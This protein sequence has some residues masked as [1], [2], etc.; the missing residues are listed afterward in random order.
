MTTGQIRGLQCFIDLRNTGRSG[1]TYKP[2][3]KKGHILVPYAWFL[4]VTPIMTDADI[5]TALEAAII[6]GLHND[7]PL[8]RWQFIGKYEGFEDKSEAPTMQK[9][10]YGNSVKVNDGTYVHE[11]M[12]GNGQDYHNV[13]RTYDGKQDQFKVLA[14]DPSGIVDGANQYGT[15]GRIVGIQGIE[16]DLR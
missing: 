2:K 3:F 6:A 10:G 8:L 4:T 11:Y 5:A 15:P 12:H 14:V 7:D 16:L 13:L 1:C 9:K